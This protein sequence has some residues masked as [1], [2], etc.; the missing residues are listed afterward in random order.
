[1][2]S[3]SCADVVA[4]GLVGLRRPALQALV[5]GQLEMTKTRHEKEHCA[6]GDADLA[7]QMAKQAR[8]TDELAG[9]VSSLRFRLAIIEDVSR[10]IIEA[11]TE[12]L[13]GAASL[14]ATPTKPCCALDV[15]V[16]SVG[17]ADEHD[18][19][20]VDGR[21]RLKHLERRI[22]AW[23]STC[24]T[25][26][27]EGL[28]DAATMALYGDRTKCMQHL[29]RGA[30]GNTE[31]ME[32]PELPKL[33]V[34]SMEGPLS[35]RLGRQAER[36]PVNVAGQEPHGGAEP[37]PQGGAVSRTEPPAQVDAGTSPAA[38]PLHQELGQAPHGR[39]DSAE[40]DPALVVIDERVEGHLSEVC[41]E[42]MPWLDV[43]VALPQICPNV[44]SEGPAP[45]CPPGS[46][47]RGPPGWYM[48]YGTS[49]RARRTAN[50][51]PS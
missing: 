10:R 34:R 45:R 4:K 6:G 30:L 24:P 1:M 16:E 13:D 21:Q 51:F 7:S 26:A 8:Q 15:S 33:P 11:V 9:E 37:T 3:S 25:S 44:T 2:A 18:A 36:E 49:S 31:P 47:P 17:Q 12:L 14:P 22:V 39:Q 43:S 38:L 19:L 23:E 20:I 32:L 35:S 40:R 29:V 46:T 42:R 27:K 50:S 28:A 48:C 5:H 41:A